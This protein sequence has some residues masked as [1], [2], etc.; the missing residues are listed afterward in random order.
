[1]TRALQISV[2]AMVRFC[3]FSR[4]G[5][6]AIEGVDT[7]SEQ[8]ALARR[9]GIPQA[10][11][12]DV[13]G[14]LACHERGSLDAVLL[15]DVIEHLAAQ[16]LFDL[17]DSVYRVLAPSGICLVHVPNAEGLYGMRIRYGDFTHET[18]FTSRSASQ[19]FK[20]IGFRKVEAYEDKPVV[21]GA[22][23]I[24]RRILWDSLTLY[25]RILL[26]AETGARGAILS[27]NFLIRATK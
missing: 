1:M 25:H 10:E 22:R 27:Q 18:A 5:Y 4:A 11:L 7:S 23:S 24:A 20:S 17:L 14:F 15:M 26:F 8:I 6:T 9:L 16:E 21:H 12:G 3:I 13:G 2:A 19:V